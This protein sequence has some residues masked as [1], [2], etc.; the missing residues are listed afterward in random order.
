MFQTKTW[1]ARQ[2]IGLNK[3]SI[4]GA[5][6][7]TLVNMPDQVI[8][9]GDAFS[10]ENMNDLERRIAMACAETYGVKID[11][12]NSNPESAV[13][14]TDGAAGLTPSS[15][16][17]GSFIPGSWSDKYP[18]NKIRPCLVKN[19]AVVG[20][21]NPDN[22]AQFEDGTAA[23][24]TSGAAGDVMVEIPI[25]YYKISHNDTHTFV[26]ISS[27]P[28]DGF[29]DKAFRY[30]G[31]L[32][33]AFYA[34]AYSGYVDSSNKL[35]S[36]SGKTP[37]GSKTIG[38]FRTAAHA[39]GDGYEQLN[40]YKLTALQILYL[41]RYKSLNSQAALGQGYTG[42]SA[43]AQTGATDAKGMNYGDTSTTGRVKCNGIE[44][45]FGNIFQWVDGYKATSTTMVKTADGNFNDN[46]NGYEEHPCTVP[47]NGGYLKDVVGDNELAFTP[48]TFSGSSSTYYADYGSLDSGFLPAFGGSWAGGAG[49]G[50]FCLSCRYSASNSRP[51]VGARLLLCKAKKA[52]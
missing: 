24:I 12:S 51:N 15:G 7:V 46:A 17:G 26:Q 33:D 3:F 21:L 36:L 9:P 6:P 48:K 43:A 23:D 22:Y 14:Y 30:N 34:G 41:I 37:T 50:A 38:A 31:E 16:N 8:V 47:N 10:E 1:R 18:F 52:A 32:T 45:F 39:N 29:T 4:G 2:G 35:R 13:E 49:A 25:F 28:L 44:D 42:G 40:F 27:A 11:K 19:G 5:A 20:Y